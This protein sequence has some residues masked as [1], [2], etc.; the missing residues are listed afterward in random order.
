MKT[1]LTSTGLRAEW[2]YPGDLATPVYERVTKSDGYGDDADQKGGYISM[3]DKYV[4]KLGIIKDYLR[5][6]LDRK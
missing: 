4:S 6:K 2:A 5:A 1:K 3:W